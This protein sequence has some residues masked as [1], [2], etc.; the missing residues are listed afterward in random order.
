MKPGD[1]VKLEFVFKDSLP[2]FSTWPDKVGD[3]VVGKFKQGE[4]GLIL[5]TTVP[6]GGNG[7]RILTSDI[8]G[9]FNIN[10]LVKA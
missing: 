4:I 1:L 3:K 5:E 8:I 10:F 6:N 2:I 7:A 9:W